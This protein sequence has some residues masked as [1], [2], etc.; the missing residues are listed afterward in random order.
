MI[1]ADQ[2]DELEHQAASA[3]T[4]P[5][6]ALTS[7]RLTSSPARRSTA[8]WATSAATLCDLAQRRSRA[9]PIRASASA[10]FRRGRRRARPD[11]ARPRPSAAPGPPSAAPAPGHAP[12]PRPPPAG[13]APASASSRRRAARSR[14]AAMR[15]CR[16]SRISASAAAPCAHQVVEGDEGDDQPEDLA[17][18]GAGVEL[19]HA[20]AMLALGT[21]IGSVG[22]ML[23]GGA[24]AS[25]RLADP[26]SCRSSGS[27]AGAPWRRSASPC[28]AP[29]ARQPGRAGRATSIVRRARRLQPAAVRTRPDQ[30]PVS[31]RLS[32]RHPDRPEPARMLPSGEEDEERDQQREQRHRFHQREAD[33][34]ER[35]H[36]LLHRGVAAD[37]CDQ[38]REDVADADADTEQ[39]DRREAS[40][41]RL[42]AMLKSEPS[43]RSS[44]RV[45][46]LR[47]W[48]TTTAGASRG[49]RTY[50][51]SACGSRR[52]G[53]CR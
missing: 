46:L 12:R 35:E 24:V 7:P 2:E 13:A 9:A 20:A 53:R 8:A 44:P 15:S 38:R 10:S 34:R 39:G 19:G 37:G 16:A 1:R 5:S 42:L 25:G 11:A 23:L 51:L 33:D 6:A 45:D 17:R 47:R 49:W 43:I 41:Y 22:A 40:A 21:M 4:R 3:S 29:A 27:A 50:A 48:S 31:P 28:R 14:S 36:A 32:C 52:S 30:S 18:E 26:G